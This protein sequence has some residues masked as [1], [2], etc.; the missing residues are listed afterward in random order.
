[1]GASTTL[2]DDDD[3]GLAARKHS[4]HDCLVQISLVVSLTAVRSTDCSHDT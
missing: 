4:V 2:E 1:M 3:D